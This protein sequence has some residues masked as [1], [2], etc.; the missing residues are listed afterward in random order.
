MLMKI[1]IIIIIDFIAG[2]ALLIFGVDL[3]SKGLESANLKPLK[4]Y[5]TAATGRLHYAF[6]AGIAATM[7]V[8]SSTA[9]TVITV[10]FVN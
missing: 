10:S 7:L 5:L 8:Q 3:M 2:I 9:V 1:A 4:K 6:L